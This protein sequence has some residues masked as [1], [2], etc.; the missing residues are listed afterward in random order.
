MSGF[1]FDLFVIGGGSGGVRA[2]RI[3]AGHGA[4]VA[5]AE[6][7][8]FGGTCVNR[9]CVPKKLMVYASRYPMEVASAAAFGW[10]ASATGF[11]WNTLIG[12]KDVE[13]ERLNG[14]YLRNV[15]ASGVTVFASRATVVDP[16]TLQ[17]ADGRSV[18][19]R[20]ILVAV[21]GHPDRGHDFPGRDLA[22]TSDDLF[23]L[24][25]LPRRTLI[26]GGGYIAVEFAGILA[27]LGSDTTLLYRAEH[28]LRGFDDELRLALEDA[29]RQRGITLRSQARVARID[30]A[31]AA[32]TVTLE[33]GGTLDV[34]CVLLCTGRRPNVAGLGL[35]AAGVELDDKGAVR[36]DALSQSSVPSIYAVGD[37]T[38]RVN[39]T[40][41]AIREG[42]AFAD[43][44]FGGKPTPVDHAVVP[45]AVF[46][47][48]ELGTVGL[49]EAKARERFPQLKVFRSSFR[50]MKASLS[51][52]NERVVLKLLV[53]GADSDRIVG[54]HMLGEGAG[55]LI[56]LL[57]VALTMRATKADFDRTLAVHPTVAEEWVTL[58][59][60]S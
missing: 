52:G 32:L 27:G 14:I 36:V 5:I 21:G 42:Q 59:T 60:A 1:D 45:T 10:Q 28:L 37:V 30:R 43:T 46:S 4:K 15:E 47:T 55:E 48:P 38:N 53:D 6:E 58:R 3:A 54:A 35:E 34:D 19:A 29:Y 13:I 11:D 7:D 22:I 44:V 9:G 2:A 33:D 12:N 20:V 56:Q 17:L 23:H 8:R 16:H 31:G 40:P 50:P 41:A 25:A 26:V 49:T 18:T 51:G 57:G 39:L 24:P